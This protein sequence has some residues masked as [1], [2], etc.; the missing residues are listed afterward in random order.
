MQRCTHSHFKSCA[1]VN[2]HA[3]QSD[4]TCV[5]PASNA[6]GAMCGVSCVRRVV[7]GEQGRGRR[8]ARSAAKRDF[9]LGKINCQRVDVSAAAVNLDE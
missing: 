8:A 5:S 2:I 6:G 1:I 7:W 3:A 9:P 4:V